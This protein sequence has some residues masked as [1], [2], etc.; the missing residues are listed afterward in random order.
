MD[1]GRVNSPSGP[2]QSS[3]PTTTEKRHAHPLLHLLGRANLF[4]PVRDILTQC[5][6]LSWEH[7]PLQ[8]LVFL[9]WCR[10]RFLSRSWQRRLAQEWPAHTPSS[11]FSSSRWRELFGLLVL[12][13]ITGARARTHLQHIAHLLAA[14]LVRLGLSLRG[15]FA[16]QLTENFPGSCFQA[17]Q[18]HTSVGLVARSRFPPSWSPLRRSCSCQVSSSFSSACSA[19]TLWIVVRTPWCLT[20]LLSRSTTSCT[21][22]HSL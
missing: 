1:Q 18:D 5:W 3:R 22:F 20:Q 4:Q 14:H 10:R 9:R 21:F 6:W 15:A 19:T 17:L 7:P 12:E 16:L 13:E 2:H 11:I 8:G